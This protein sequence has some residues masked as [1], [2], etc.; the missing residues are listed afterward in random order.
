MSKRI[1]VASGGATNKLRAILIMDILACLPL[2]LAK[3]RSVRVLFDAVEKNRLPH[4]ILFYGGSARALEQVCLGLA[5]KILRVQAEKSLDFH[6]VRPANKSRTIGIENVLGLV[7]EIQQSPAFGERKVAC[8]YDADRLGRDSANAF[9]KTLEEPPAGT[10]IFLMTTAVNKVLPTI[11]SRCLHFR[12]PGEDRIESEEWRL[13]LRDFE[14]WIGSLVGGEAIS[15]IG[16]SVFSVYALTVRFQALVKEVA[17][18][19]WGC[20][21]NALPVGVNADQ[22]DAM[23]VGISRGV[24]HRLL[25]EMQEAFLRLA[26]RGSEG[27]PL[28]GE[29]ARSC[30]LLEQFNRLLELN[31]QDGAVIEAFLLNCLRIWSKKKC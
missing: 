27:I 13:W 1:F 10:F 2:F 16:M 18:L 14:A 5:S 24:R 23:Q 28:V 15:D 6:V 17:D 3:A 22:K 8:I 7:R 4:G 25:S 12:I 9:L 30:A 31:A 19:E 20:V 11:R 21:E 26:L 29:A